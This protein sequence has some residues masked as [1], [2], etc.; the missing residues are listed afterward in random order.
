MMFLLLPEKCGGI[1]V[2]KFYELNIEETLE[3]FKIFFN[4]IKEEDMLE[5]LVFISP[6]GIR[7]RM[8]T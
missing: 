5:N 7:I 3:I 2:V 1:V 6:E 4:S 8:I